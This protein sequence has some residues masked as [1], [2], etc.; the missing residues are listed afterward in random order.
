MSDDVKVRASHWRFRAG[1][2]ADEALSQQRRDHVEAQRHSLWGPPEEPSTVEVLSGIGFWT[3]EEEDGVVSITG[4][5]ESAQWIDSPRA[6][7]AI[8]A[9]AP[10]SLPGSYVE[11]ESEYDSDPTRWVLHEGQVRE[12]DPTVL[13]VLPGDQGPWMVGADSVRAE[14]EEA[15]GVHGLEAEVAAAIVAMDD[16]E[17]NDAVH[18]AVNDYHWSA[19]DDL[20]GTAIAAL[21]ARAREAL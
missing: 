20:R 1:P 13:W 8:T 5:T 4:G 2:E 12:I 19:H 6:L 3:E 18:A 11:V 21:A 10:L 15:P 7:A 17:L 9:L 16:K 14:V